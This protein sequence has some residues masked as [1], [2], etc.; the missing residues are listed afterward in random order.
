MVAPRVSI[1]RFRCADCGQELAS[2]ERQRQAEARQA[3]WQQ[4]R[5]LIGLSRFKLGLSVRKTQALVVFVYGR[6]VAVGFIQQQTQQLGL[7]A[8]QV[9]ERLKDCRQKAAPLSIV[10]IQTIVPKLGINIIEPPQQS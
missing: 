8:Q 5:R 9:L 2:A 4:V 10:C 3:W 1:Q 7:R 6:Q